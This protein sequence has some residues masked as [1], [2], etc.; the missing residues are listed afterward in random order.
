MESTSVAIKVKQRSGRKMSGNVKRLT[1]NVDIKN[2]DIY[3]GLLNI[4]Q[5]I[6]EDER[7]PREA[8]T[9]YLARLHALLQS[10]RQKLTG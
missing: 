7:I 1:I 6:V 9:E 2:L 4:L 10:E 3:N 8:R 5:E